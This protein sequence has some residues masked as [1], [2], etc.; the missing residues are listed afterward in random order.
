MELM[1]LPNELVELIAQK[2][3]VDSLIN[4]QFT[5]RRIREVSESMPKFIKET[6]LPPSTI[7]Y[8]RRTGASVRSVDLSDCHADDERIRRIVQSCPHVEDLKLVNTGLSYGRLL[9]VIEPLRQI[10]TLS[11]TLWSPDY[12]PLAATYL[13]S[14]QNI[15]KLHVE[16][17]PTRVALS[18]LVE[19]TKACP[20][21][22]TCHVNLTDEG[23]CSDGSDKGS[24]LP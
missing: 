12:F 4:F 10:K 22:E 13:K 24:T 9:E 19:L 3:D 2:L 17:V 8:L 16:L 23:H 21:L 15:R 1:N 7:G 11:F 5:N 18:L 6:K 14:L 20:R